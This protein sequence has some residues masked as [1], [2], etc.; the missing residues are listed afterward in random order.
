MAKPKQDARPDP[1][2]REAAAIREATA[3]VRARG[4]RLK[5]SVALNEGTV[6]T[7]SPHSDEQGWCARLSDAFGSNS[8]AFV[9]AEVGRYL[10]TVRPAFGAD[11]ETETNALLAMLDGAKPK[12]E[13]EALLVLQIAATH[14]HAMAQLQKAAAAL[15]I[16]GMAA[17]GNLATKLQR[18]MVA[19]I[20]ALAKLRRGGEQTVRVE[21]VHVHAGAQAIVGSV[22]AGAGLPPEITR[23]NHGTI[24]PRTIAVTAGPPVWGPS[25]YGE[26][27]P[28]A[29]GKR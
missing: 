6:S 13:I 14:R 29:G 19:Q 27:L 11:A 4:P 5:A 22:Q 25:S 26:P 18:T 1:T 21:H 3:K 17:H 23:Q 10:T 9:S 7:G 16:D 15:Y 20:E 28:E 8:E 12:D 24:D 2:E